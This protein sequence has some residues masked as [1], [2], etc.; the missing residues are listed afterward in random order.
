MGTRCRVS[1]SGPITSATSSLGRFWSKRAKGRTKHDVKGRFTR[2][3]DAAVTCRE[4]RHPRLRHPDAHYFAW[5]ANC[6]IEWALIISFFRTLQR[7]FRLIQL[8]FGSVLIVCRPLL[9][10]T[11]GLVPPIKCPYNSRL[12]RPPGHNIASL[13]GATFSIERNVLSSSRAMEIS[14]DKIKISAARD[15]MEW[16]LGFGLFPLY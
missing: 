3:I 11:P 4:S 13:L 5:R 16:P 10:T 1:S 9:D 6:P 12:S 14:I 15:K 2:L 7:D 8:T